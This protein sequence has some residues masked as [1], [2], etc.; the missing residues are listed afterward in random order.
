MLSFRYSWQAFLAL[1]Q[2]SLF[3]GWVWTSS[4]LLVGAEG[5]SF[6]LGLKRAW[7]S[8][9]ANHAVAWKWRWPQKPRNKDLGK[10]MEFWKD[11]LIT[12]NRLLFLSERNAT[13]CANSRWN[14]RI[15]KVYVLTEEASYPALDCW[16]KNLFAFLQADNADCSPAFLV[17]SCKGWHPLKIERRRASGLTRQTLKTTGLLQSETK[18]TQ[19]TTLRK[20]VN[21]QKQ[22][23]A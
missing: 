21:L 16:R 5:M 10:V 19:P 2:L 12:L 6:W 14:S 23:A 9:L 11:N 17:V 15:F 18:L 7:F 1:L 8:D 3:F 22:L 4:F 20:P 13:S